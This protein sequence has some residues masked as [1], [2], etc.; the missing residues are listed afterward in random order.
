MRSD[1]APTP[2]RLV[3]HMRR[4]STGV[5]IAVDDTVEDVLGWSP[6]QLIGR[7]SSSLIHPEDQASAVAAWIDMA[8][9]AGASR[10]WRGRYQ[11]ADGAWRW[12]ETTNANRLDDSTNPAVLTSMM[13]VTV[14][15]VGA[16]EAL[17]ARE[18]IITRLSDA[19]PVGIFQID[20]HRNV[21]FTN[22][23]LHSLV[24]C[25]PAATTARQFVAVVAED[26][27]TL[28]S[29]LAAVL[30][31]QAV[32]DVELRLRIPAHDGDHPEAVLDRVCL[33]SLR[34]LTDSTAQVTGAIGCLS[35]A[36]DRVNLR[37]QLELRASV[38]Q[39]T[40]CLNRSATLELLAGALASR[41]PDRGVAV[42]FV[43]LDHFKAVNDNFGHHAGDRVL[44]AAASSLR[45]VVRGR[46]QVGRIGGDE[47]LVICPD[48]EN[49][50]QALEIG[51][52]VADALTIEVDLGEAITEL[53]ASVGIAWTCEPSDPDGL[54]AVAD[55]AMYSS[56]KRGLGTAV[57]A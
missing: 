36:T 50:V 14:D 57:I 16:E 44:V 15:Q 25:P 6:A 9:V 19:L 5:I 55:R 51:A 29:A 26:Q 17:R 39:L 41:V 4:D 13:A 56:K 38:D 53:R 34:S 33:L 8:T 43:D 46:D 37:R 3:V 2:D 21:V 54:I 47:F 1:S 7:A 18:Q 23:R 28:D 52:R 12:V 22:D 45:G 27:T 11:S 48:V 49:R 35:D 40:G 32:D 10:V 31:D 24:G 42:V 20:A 30:D